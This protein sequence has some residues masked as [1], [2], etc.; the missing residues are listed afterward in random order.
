MEWT[1]TEAHRLI[2]PYIRVLDGINIVCFHFTG[3]CSPPEYTR[4][5]TH[6]HTNFNAYLLVYFSAFCTASVLATAINLLIFH[7]YRTLYARRFGATQKMRHGAHTNGQMFRTK[8][9]RVL[10]LARLASRQHFFSLVLSLSGWIFRCGPL[11][12][13]CLVSGHTTCV[14]CYHFFVVVAEHFFSAWRIF[15]YPHNACVCVAP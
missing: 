5:H 1:A 14:A 7:Q 3:V 10:C 13:H 15:Q 2:A 12:C 8:L 6:S 11:F 4:T 9:P